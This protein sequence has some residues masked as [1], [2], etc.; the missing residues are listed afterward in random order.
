MRIKNQFYPFVCT[1]VTVIYFAFSLLLLSFLNDSL[2]VL[3][4]YIF[5]PALFF[6]LPNVFPRR[7]FAVILV[8]NGL[9]LDL[10]HHLPLGFSPL[11]FIF[12]QTWF[13]IHIDFKKE[14]FSKNNI[15]I[16]MGIN[17]LISLILY[18]FFYFYFEMKSTWHFSKFF[19]DLSIS[20]L[21][22]FMIVHANK[23]ILEKIFRKFQMNDAP[24]GRTT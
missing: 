2:S 9:M 20:T 11:I 13:R 23:L 24:L 17:I 12:L 6:I 1:M 3:G 14:T 8:V 15:L 10:Y 16:Y 5:M 22:L 4:I 19:L 21:F 7:S 18:F